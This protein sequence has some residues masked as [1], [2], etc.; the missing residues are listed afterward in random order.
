MTTSPQLT[1][2]KFRC[3]LHGRIALQYVMIEV[4]VSISVMRGWVLLLELDHEDSNRCVTLVCDDLSNNHT[5]VLKHKLFL[6][7]LFVSV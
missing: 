4:Y 5:K 3:E 2:H 1:L 7:V 6:C